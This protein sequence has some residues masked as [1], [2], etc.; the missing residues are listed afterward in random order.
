VRLLL[1]SS[2]LQLPP[3]KAFPKINRDELRHA[4]EGLQLEAADRIDAQLGAVVGQ[5]IEGNRMAT[6]RI[7]VPQR[8]I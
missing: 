7:T 6:A 8:L 2:K 3:P 4:I 1:S 5:A